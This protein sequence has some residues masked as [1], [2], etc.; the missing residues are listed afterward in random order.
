[1]K[2]DY[3]FLSAFYQ[4]MLIAE[5]IQ[6]FTA[7]HDRRLYTVSRKSIVI[8]YFILFYKF[9]NCREEWSSFFYD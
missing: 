1:M 7:N 4:R 8:Y 2:I 9:L 3:V 5:R 6:S